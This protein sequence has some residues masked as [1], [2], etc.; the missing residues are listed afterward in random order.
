MKKMLLAGCSHSAGFGLTDKTQSWGEIFAKNNEHSLTNVAVAASSLQYA[1]Q[2]IIDRISQENYD[3]VILQLTTL[4]RYP[5][6]FNGENRFLK[7]DILNVNP[8]TPDI[9]HLVPANYLES[10]EGANLPVNADNVRFFYEK[11]MYSSFYLN[12]IFN[13]IY[14]LQ[15]VLKYKGID[16]ILIP[17]DDYF[18][19]NESYMSVW[20]HPGSSKIDKSR[21]IDYPFMKWLRDNYNPDDYYMDKGFHLNEAGHIL[22]AEEYLPKFI[23]IKKV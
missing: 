2:S 3:T 9:F 12:T 22:F 7:D 4:D 13:E 1:I 21:Y 16:F 8:S 10:I 15:E 23:Q 5:I 14:L 6:T 11:V 17:Y 19:G 20:R 18:W